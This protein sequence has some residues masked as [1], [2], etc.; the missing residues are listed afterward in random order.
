MAFAAP[1]T[2]IDFLD[3]KVQA[4][5]FYEMQVRSL[6]K[7]FSPQNELDLAQW[8][9]VLDLEIEANLVEDSHGPLDL[10]S[11]FMRFEF[12]YDCV[13]KRGCNLFPNVNAYGDKTGLGQG[14][15]PE[16][17]Q[18]GRRSGFHG[19][20]FI[21]DTQPYLFQSLGDA[22]REP[23]VPGDSLGGPSIG[24]NTGII[25]G[26]LSGRVATQIWNTDTFGSTYAVAYGPDGVFGT[27]D[28]IASR[29]YGW[30]LGGNGKRCLFGSRKVK[31]G[32]IAGY[33]TR[34]LP[35][36]PRCE[37]QPRGVIRNY[38]NPFRAGDFNPAVGGGGLDALPF[39][40]AP[41]FGSASGNANKAVAQ[42]I[43]YPN[44]TLANRI[45][46]NEFSAF[47]Q[48][49][50]VDELQWNLGASQQRGEY[51]LKEAYFD[52]EMFDS[53]LWLRLGKQAVVWGKTELFRNQ[54]RINPQDL[55]L[56]S[57]PTLE[58]SRIALWAARAVWSFYEVGPFED[59]RLEGVAN[60]DQFEPADLGRCG[61]PFTALVVCDKT[62]G[63]MAHGVTG[64]GVAGEI[65]PNDPWKDIGDL[66][67][68][69]RLE[70]RYDRFSFSL[71]DFYGFQDLPFNHIDQKFERNVEPLYRA[72]P[73]AE[74]PW[75]LHDGGRA[76][77][78]DACQRVDEPLGEPADVRLDLRLDRGG[79]KRPT[80][81]QRLLRVPPEFAAQ[82]DSLSS[83]IDPQLCTGRKQAR[84]RHRRCS[85]RLQCACQP[86][87]QPLRR[88]LRR[89]GGLRGV[90]TG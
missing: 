19:S 8:Y 78:P 34:D 69:V 38:P 28:D 24:N 44:H 41:L 82:R 64:A 49:F 81:G 51:F 54:D 90:C 33:T 56:T 43:Y 60:I 89:C 1:A 9:H 15:L 48:N 40:P 16:R 87:R 26:R 66:E 25:P 27:P 72:P 55:A 20:Q 74:L 10:V 7:D 29:L 77:L 58:E 79:G 6:Q 73:P 84:C 42:G 61:E 75:P 45:R 86:Q 11:S 4:H 32:N 65:R 14:R 5:G 23:G 39:R 18:G 59:V 70:W 13:W 50:S 37:I 68:G 85:H 46:H 62:F 22:V 83:G 35:W 80:R 71:T 63:L 12:R 47:D 30:A 36:N 3:G 88:S 2:A 57:L 52:I 31:S 53:R 21:G 67:G 76:G 17:V